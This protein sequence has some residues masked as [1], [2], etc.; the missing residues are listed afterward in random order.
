MAVRK[1]ALSCWVMQIMNSTCSAVADHAYK[2][3]IVRDVN[4]DV[5]AAIAWTGPTGM[6]LVIFAANTF[7]AEE[8]DRKKGA[9]IWVCHL[10]FTS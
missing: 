4:C 6:L 10:S 1:L 3:I 5:A 7:A 9:E 2:F 8:F